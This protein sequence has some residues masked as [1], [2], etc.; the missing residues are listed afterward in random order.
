MNKKQHITTEMARQ[1][2]T[3][4][5]SQNT[6]PETKSDDRTAVVSVGMKRS[7]ITRLAAIAAENGVTRKNLMVYALRRFIRKY[8]AGKIRI[9][10][11]GT[12]EE[13]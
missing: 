8:D 6:L 4:L 2:E 9:V 3:F 12:A 5:E 7:E 11:D 10:K 13:K 1:T